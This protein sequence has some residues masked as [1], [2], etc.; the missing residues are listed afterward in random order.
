VFLFFVVFCI[1]LLSHRQIS[2]RLLSLLQCNQTSSR[3]M[4]ASVVTC[5]SLLFLSNIASSE[6]L[7]SLVSRLSLGL[8]AFF[9]FTWLSFSMHAFIHAST[10]DNIM[11]S[12]LINIFSCCFVGFLLFDVLS[13][14]TLLCF[15]LF[16]PFR[17]LRLLSMPTGQ[18]LLSNQ[19]YLVLFFFH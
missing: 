10:C 18:S 12:L 14:Y 2:F 7:S 1:D 6:K 5:M 13:I 19:M 16:F 4:I 11:C 8:F 3:Q 15:I 17:F 9:V